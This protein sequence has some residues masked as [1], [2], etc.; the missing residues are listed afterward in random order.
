MPSSARVLTA[1]A[2]GSIWGST[3]TEYGAT[4]GKNYADSNE[5]IFMDRTEVNNP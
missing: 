4:E 1:F 2:D 5:I 3:P